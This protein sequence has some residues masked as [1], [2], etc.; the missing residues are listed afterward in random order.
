MLMGT[1]RAIRG[2][3]RRP[4][5]GCSNLFQTN[6]S[7]TCRLPATPS[8]LGI[9]PVIYTELAAAVRQITIRYRSQICARIPRFSLDEQS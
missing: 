6:L 5:Y 7:L 2:S 8:G 3:H 1:M 4:A 9:Y